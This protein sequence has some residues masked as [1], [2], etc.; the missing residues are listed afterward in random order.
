VRLAAQ[1][2]ASHV[3]FLSMPDTADGGQALR[4]GGQSGIFMWNRASDDAT[5]PVLSP[6]GIALSVAPEADRWY[7]V[8][9]RADGPAGALTTW[10]D[11]VTVEGLAAD[12]TPTADVDDH[13]ISGGWHPTL[14]TFRL[15]WESYA[16]QA[17]TLWFDDVAL[18]T[19]R[20]GCG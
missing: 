6:A 1:L 3:S 5:L 15:G 13:W 18:G 16:G 19:E 8:E 11:G 12:A 2:G 20:V 9:F 17:M 7:C 14:P 10:V 4:M